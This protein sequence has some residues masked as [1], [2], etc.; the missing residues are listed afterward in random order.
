MISP[1][2][3]KSALDAG[4]TA[5]IACVAMGVIVYITKEHS[6]QVDKFDRTIHENTM[7]IHDFKGTQEESTKV[8]G[9][10]KD[11]IGKLYTELIEKAK[12]IREYELQQRRKVKSS[13]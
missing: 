1:E 11:L 7:V 8:I 12:A 6:K 9:E 10:L 2:L 5:F 4:P 13:N 3:A